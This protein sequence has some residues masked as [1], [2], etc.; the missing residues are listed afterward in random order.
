M[1][2]GSGRFAQL[3]ART[4]AQLALVLLIVIIEVA[5]MTAIATGHRDLGRGLVGL[6]IVLSMPATLWM[7]STALP[8]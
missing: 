3:R 6:G 7:R 2:Q 5:G 1:T 8:R 4:P